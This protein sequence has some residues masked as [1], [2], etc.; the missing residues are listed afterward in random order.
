M[1][2]WKELMKDEVY[3]QSW[4]DL[5]V[6]KSEQRQKGHVR[7]RSHVEE[8]LNYFIHTSTEESCNC[9]LNILLKIL[10][11]STNLLHGIET[12]RREGQVTEAADDLLTEDRYLDLNVQ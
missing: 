11:G 7:R 8:I 5:G 2:G 10:D 3:D 1:M 12:S 9:L 6:W 4:Y